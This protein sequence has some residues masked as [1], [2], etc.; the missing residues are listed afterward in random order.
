MT[1]RSRR[2]FWAGGS[3]T[4]Y[5]ITCRRCWKWWQAPDLPAA[6]AAAMQHLAEY[7]TRI[8]HP[9]ETAQED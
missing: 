7:M 2:P 3:G 1:I 8:E 4:N 5:W 9:T 6:F